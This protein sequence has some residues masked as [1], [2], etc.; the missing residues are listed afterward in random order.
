MGRAEWVA[1][2]PVAHRGLHDS[3]AGIIE[4]TASAF[5]AAMAEGYGME[6]DVQMSSDGEAMAFHDDTVDRLLEGRG[7]V[8]AKTRAELQSMPMREGRDRMITLGDLCDL[9]DGRAPLIVEVKASW[10]ADRRLEDRVAS[11]LHGYRGPVAVMSFD[12]ES[13]ATFRRI[14]PRLP[15][16]VVQE[17]VYDDPEWAGLSVWQKFR[18]GRCLHLPRSRPDFLAWYVKDL[19]YRTPRLVRALLGLPML[20]WTVRTPADQARAAL[21]ADQMIFEGFR[22]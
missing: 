13:T 11:V 12:P 10:S 3:A 2:R 9:V 5:A 17:S 19:E 16:G 22:P 8:D 21:F 1:E 18:L 20:T 14:A 6:C 4:N 15:R 7:R